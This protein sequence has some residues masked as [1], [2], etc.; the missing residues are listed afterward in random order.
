MAEK[1]TSIK[2]IKDNINSTEFH[3]KKELGQNFLIDDNIINKIIDNSNITKDDCVLEIGP[4]MGSL[5]YYLAQKCDKLVAIEKDD[6]LIEVLK[7]NFSD[8]EN[9]ALIHD[10]VLK[11][12]F[13]E[14]S[15]LFKSDRKIKVISNLPYSITSAVII[16]LLQHCDIFET[17]TL[18]MQKEVAARLTALPS[19]KDYGSLTLAVEYYAK[20]RILLNVPLTVFY[21]KP[22]VDSSVV[23]FEIRK[24]PAVKTE[25]EKEMFALVRAA[26][27]TRR[28]TLINTLSASLGIDKEKIKLGLA[29]LNLDENIRGEA[30]NLEQFAMLTDILYK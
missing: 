22:K 27:A 16:K 3:F 30:L 1:T 10:D 21:P 5:T 2:Y 17:L 15:N 20:T 14:L 18:M 8:T 24:T 11:Y 28:K 6:K 23:F 13:S 12:D 4:G 19:T 9:V 25:H 7:S 29:K 26:F